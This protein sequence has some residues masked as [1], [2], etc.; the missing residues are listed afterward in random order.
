MKLDARPRWRRRRSVAMLET[1]I[2]VSLLLPVSV[3]SFDVAA[4][5]VAGAEVE[6]ALHTAAEQASRLTGGVNERCGAATCVDTVFDAQMNS[7]I[8]RFIVHSDDIEVRAATSSDRVCTGPDDRITLEAS[9]ATKAW[10]RML[11][12]TLTG[13]VNHTVTAS[14]ACVIRGEN[15]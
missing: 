11:I 6:Q 9:F 10:S 2:A 15:R 3:L 13:E 5:K 8:S 7:A 1:V 12:G 14:V 4:M